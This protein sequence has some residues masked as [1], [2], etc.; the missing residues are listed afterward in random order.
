MARR[1]DERGSGLF[2]ERQN[3][4]LLRRSCRFLCFSLNKQYLDFE[5]YF[6]VVFSLK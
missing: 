2:G 1:G 4:N 3:L 6:L 5:L